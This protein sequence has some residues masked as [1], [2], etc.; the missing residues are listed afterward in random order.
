MRRANTRSRPERAVPA[1]AD[2][3][4]ASER[5]AD[6]AADRVIAGH[7]AAHETHTAPAEG[8]D[9]MRPARAE[10]AAVTRGQGSRLPAP[11]RR[12]FEARFGRD[13]SGIRL[14]ADAAA[15][16]AARGIGASAFT[17]GNHIAFAPRAYE[18]ETPAGRHLLGHEIAH[19]LQQSTLARPVIQRQKPTMNPEIANLPWQRHL[20]AFKEAHYDLD[21]RAVG[22]NLSTWLTLAYH[23]GAEID[24]ALD[25]IEDRDAPYLESWSNGYLGTMGRVFP[26]ELTRTT[27]PKLWSAKKEAIAIMEEYNY[28]FMLATLPAVLFIIFVAGTPQIGS[29]P[30]SRRMTRPRPKIRTG[31][32]KTTPKTTGPAAPAAPAAAAVGSSTFR[33]V[34]SKVLQYGKRDIIV[35]E[36]SAGRQAFYRRTG[37]GGKNAGGAKAGEWAPFDGVMAGWFDKA[38]Y[39]TG[40]ADDVLYRF[41]TEENRRVSEWLATQAIKAGD[42]VGEVFSIVN[43]Y[44]KDLGALKTPGVP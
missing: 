38:R 26:K 28:N 34:G 23:D 12:F 39:V 20:D 6:A 40:S 1:L 5:A 18:P 8:T 2:H 22:G 33:I 41:G 9:E 25:K 36:T 21:Y 29:M 3:G 24:L 30:V 42:D 17:I 16:A 14:H 37:M 7:F 31:I 10:A 32:P 27:C 11:E 43:Q 19:S 13:L 15:G 4:S 44:L 35:V